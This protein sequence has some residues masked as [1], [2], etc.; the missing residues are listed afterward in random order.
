MPNIVVKVNINELQEEFQRMEV[1]FETSLQK[2]R[3]DHYDEI[4][5]LERDLDA[6]GKQA[7]REYKR[8]ERLKK[9]LN[10]A[11]YDPL[12]V[13]QLEKDNAAWVINHN[14]DQKLIEELRSV[15]Q[16][17]YNDVLILRA[18][19]NELEGCLN[20]AQRYIENLED[21]SKRAQEVLL[22]G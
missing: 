15:P 8:A 2:E 18:K 7:D 5:R 22:C 13:K 20:R 12:Y 16:Y 19:C 17:D 9:E 4:L 11:T 1:E 21:R 6:V 14:S 10:N 3:S